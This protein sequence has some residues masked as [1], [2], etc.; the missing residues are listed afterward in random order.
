MNTDRVLKR[1]DSVLLHKDFVPAS[2]V[3]E[4]KRK[5]YAQTCVQMKAFYQGK[6]ITVYFDYQRSNRLNKNFI[7][8]REF[9]TG[10]IVQWIPLESETKTEQ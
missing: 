4:E 5:Q 6:E 7:V 9:E 10:K 8:L 1:T 3:Y 2:E